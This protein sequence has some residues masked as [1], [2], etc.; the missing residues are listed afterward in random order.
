MVIHRPLVIDVLGQ[1]R[2]TVERYCVAI[3]SKGSRRYLAERVSLGRS[4]E[5]HL[6]GD[7]QVKAWT[8]AATV[9]VAA[10]RAWMDS[11]ESLTTFPTFEAARD[12]VRRFRIT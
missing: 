6:D 9:D 10:L 11:D 12:V 5:I 4:G 3:V 7:H 2:D 8:P 1:G